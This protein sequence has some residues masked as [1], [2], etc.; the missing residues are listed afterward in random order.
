MSLLAATTVEDVYDITK[1]NNLLLWWMLLLY[2]AL[3]PF[4]LYYIWYSRQ[5]VKKMMHDNTEALAGIRVYFEATRSSEQR[6]NAA[7]EETK[8]VAQEVKNAVQSG[9]SSATRVG[10]VVVHTPNVEINPPQD[11]DSAI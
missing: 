7:M 1:S 9:N 8:H 2:L 4:V 10:K 6:A 3:K 11:P 5:S